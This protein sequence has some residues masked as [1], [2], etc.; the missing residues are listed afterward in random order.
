MTLSAVKIAAKNLDSRKP[1]FIRMHAVVGI[2]SDCSKR[3]RTQC[4]L[5][6]ATVEI[7]RHIEAKQRSPVCPNEVDLRADVWCENYIVVSC[8]VPNAVEVNSRG[9]FSNGR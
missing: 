1:P 9:L 6:P 7:A 8:V 3:H 4:G 2:H 5:R